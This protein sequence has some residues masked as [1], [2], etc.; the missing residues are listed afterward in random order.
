M[1]GSNTTKETELQNFVLFSPF[2]W[3]LDLF[4]WN[5]FKSTSLWTGFPGVLNFSDF[6]LRSWDFPPSPSCCRIFAP[7][8]DSLPQHHREFFNIYFFPWSKER[9][10]GSDVFERPLI[11]WQQFYRF[12]GFFRFMKLTLLWKF[13]FLLKHHGDRLTS[14]FNTQKLFEASIR[15]GQHRKMMINNQDNF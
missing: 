8:S 15:G 13:I 9:T 2:L 6:T 7:F 10:L 3:L 1:R 12:T 5:I 4:V 11:V 14:I